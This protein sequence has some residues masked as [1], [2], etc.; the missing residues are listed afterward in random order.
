MI[1]FLIIGFIAGAA[2]GLTIGAALNAEKR[3]DVIRK[4]RTKKNE[5]DFIQGQAD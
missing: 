2:S 3:A 5:R 1:A 4:R